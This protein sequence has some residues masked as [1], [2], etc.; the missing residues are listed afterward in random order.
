M[1]ELSPD[2]PK[3]Y[4][5]LILNQQWD[6]LKRQLLAC[7]PQVMTRHPISILSAYA[8][9]TKTHKYKFLPPK[10]IEWAITEYGCDPNVTTWLN[11]YPIQ[12][13]IAYNHFE[14]VKTL[15]R[16]GAN[17]NVASNYGTPLTDAVSYLN[18]PMAQ[19]LL[20]YGADPNF[21]YYPMFD[22]HVAPALWYLLDRLYKIENYNGALADHF[23]KD[24]L[25]YDTDA[26]ENF[27]KILAVLL[28]HHADPK[29]DK[30]IQSLTFLANEFEQGYH[31][32]YFPSALHEQHAR[33]FEMKLHQ[34]LQFKPKNN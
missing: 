20:D 10:M 24:L 11:L 3:N 18:Y 29:A 27:F 13:F 26:T 4:R 6:K 32:G 30:V 14:G 19:L 7:E 1:P 33:D 31:S 9:N 8:H 28:E 25:I 22:L 2:L 15:L 12:L 34:M 21:S 16:L 23:K 17:P 5:K